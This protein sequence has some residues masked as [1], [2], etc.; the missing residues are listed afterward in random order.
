MI[1]A[2]KFSR[3]LTLLMGYLLCSVAVVTS[4]RRLGAIAKASPVPAAFGLN[5]A[6][7]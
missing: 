6:N 7:F 2:I 1:I 5:V 4:L 3:R